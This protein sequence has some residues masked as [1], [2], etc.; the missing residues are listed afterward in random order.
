[1]ERIASQPPL[2]LRR[3][4]KPQNPVSLDKFFVKMM[5]KENVPSVYFDSASSRHLIPKAKGVRALHILVR[6]AHNVSCHSLQA[7]LRYLQTELFPGA[8]FRSLIS[9]W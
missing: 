4:P 8:L 6:V 9:E 3:T 1:M 2:D 7:H 5:M